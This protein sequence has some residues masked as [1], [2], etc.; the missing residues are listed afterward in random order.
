MDP[1]LKRLTM[2]A[3]RELEEAL[4]GALLEL[5]PPLPGFTTVP[6]AGHGEDFGAAQV[7]ERVRGRIDRTLLWL[8][9]PADRVDALL[10]HLRRVLPTREV[11][12]WLEPVDA[13]GRLA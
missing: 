13:L 1:V 9:M 7:H 2:I 3:P 8:V 10:T 6:V 4:V 11:V 5:D 12:W